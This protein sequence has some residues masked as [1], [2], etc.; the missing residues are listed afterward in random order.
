[1]VY[2]TIGQL[3]EF[4][5]HHRIVNGCHEPFGKRQRFYKISGHTL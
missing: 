5:I 1:M 4:L 2:R 3:V